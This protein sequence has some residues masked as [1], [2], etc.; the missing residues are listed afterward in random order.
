M[1]SN[2][3]ESDKGSVSDN[4]HTQSVDQSFINNLMSQSSV[5]TRPRFI[6]NQK[7]SVSSNHIDFNKPITFQDLLK[8][9]QDTTFIDRIN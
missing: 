4:G 5:G 1:L 3:Q 7:E 9:E 6:P 8:R 2:R